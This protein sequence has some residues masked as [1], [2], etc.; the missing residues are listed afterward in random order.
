LE[1]Q[2][3]NI[4]D[5]GKLIDFAMKYDDKGV[6]LSNFI[7]RSIRQVA[8]FTSEHMDCLR[9]RFQYSGYYCWDSK[10]DAWD[11]PTLTE[12]KKKAEEFADLAIQGLY[13]CKIGFFGN[14]LGINKYPSQYGPHG[15]ELLKDV[16]ME[17]ALRSGK[18]FPDLRKV[19]DV[20]QGY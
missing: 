18:P 6:E 1:I 17:V 13:G 19:P 4:A 14:R 5:S 8:G 20:R 11:Y 2:R 9:Y 16:N 12:S 10:W 15:N 3:Q 7:N